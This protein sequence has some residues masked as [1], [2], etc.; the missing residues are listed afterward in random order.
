[1]CG[2][3]GANLQFRKG[4]RGTD[5]T[6]IGTRIELKLAEDAVVLAIPVKMMNEAKGTLES[7]NRKGMIPLREVRAV[8]GKLSWIC[9]ILVRARWCVN[10]FFAFF[11]HRSADSG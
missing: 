2:A 10:I 4:F 11:R 9:G 1:M 3:L 8:T 5:T 7:W 6:W